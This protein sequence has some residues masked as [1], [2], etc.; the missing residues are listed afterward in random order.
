MSFLN[1]L[2]GKRALWVYMSCTYIAH[3]VV[4]FE[5]FLV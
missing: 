1:E 3:V 2:H 5:L 4:W